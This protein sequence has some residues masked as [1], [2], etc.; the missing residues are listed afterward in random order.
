MNQKNPFEFVS[1]PKIKQRSSK[2]N[3]GEEWQETLVDTGSF[4][5]KT[6]R[7]LF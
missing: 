2:K 5:P 4:K 3:Y 6:L 7:P 1:S